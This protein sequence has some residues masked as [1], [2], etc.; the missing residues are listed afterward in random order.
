MKTTILK[1]VTI[2]NNVIIGA[3]SLVNKDIPDDVVVAGN[4]AKIIMSLDEYY[5]KRKKCQ[6]QEAIECCVEYKKRYN[7]W[8]EKHEMRE[9]IWLFEPR[10][11]NSDEVFDE[12]A[13]LL[14]NYEETKTK[15]KNSKVEFNGYDEF[16]KYCEKKL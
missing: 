15:F 7:K 14:N 8:P 11:K 5:Q 6:K 16:L 2:G 13:S 1:G 9:F 3:N 10:D 12:I 4:P